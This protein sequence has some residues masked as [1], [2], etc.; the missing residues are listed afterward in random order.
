MKNNDYSEIAVLEVEIKSLS[1]MGLRVKYDLARH[2]ISWNDGYAWGNN[3]MKAIN[4]AKYQIII[5]K[6]PETDIFEW[7]T[8]YEEGNL[9]S[10][11]NSTACPSLW[12][13]DV[14]FKDGERACAHGE[15]GYPTTWNKLKMIIETT[16]ECSFR[17]R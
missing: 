12:K 17:L 4:D 16:T 3:F 8:S 11:C 2:L 13:L 6:L 7:I 10:I 14:K 1:G 15:N 5:E 9:D